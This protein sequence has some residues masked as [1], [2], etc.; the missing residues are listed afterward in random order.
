MFDAHAHLFLLPEEV[1]CPAMQRA[2][3]AGVTYIA[4]VNTDAQSLEAARSWQLPQGLHL[5]QV[6]ATPPHSVSEED[7]FFYEVE[8][9]AKAGELS[10]IGEIGFEC[11]YQN[12][13]IDRQ[14]ES[15]LRYYE[16][17]GRYRLPIVVHC[18][19]GFERLYSLLARQDLV[20]PGMMHCFTGTKADAKWLLDHHWYLSISGI[21]TYPK[22]HLLREIVAY[23][24][25][26][27]ICVETD[28]P[29]LAP[30]KM[31]GKVNEPSYL[32]HTLEVIA[33][34]RNCSIEQMCEETQKNAQDFFFSQ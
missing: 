29:Y 12:T 2:L 32:V 3:Q 21:V 9:A 22:S 28:A 11:F 14:E 1:R 27:R 20:V 31:R 23:L 26:N 25:S 17:A 10:A 8:K 7:P 16:L 18:R 24:P 6:A 15:F 33:D 34:I 5:Y 4:N 19:D 13:P 30:Q